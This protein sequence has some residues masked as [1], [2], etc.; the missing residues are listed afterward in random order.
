MRTILDSMVFVLTSDTWLLISIFLLAPSISLS[1]PI[2][3]R[4]SCR[5]VNDKSVCTDP[6]PFSFNSREDQNQLPVETLD[7][8]EHSNDRKRRDGSRNHIR[9]HEI[10]ST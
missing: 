7:V 4:K 3:E 2:D 1:P 5:F 10:S 9:Y 8:C 6:T